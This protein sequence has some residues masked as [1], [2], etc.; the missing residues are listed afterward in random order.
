MQNPMV[1]SKTLESF[2]DIR[3]ECG[4]GRPKDWYSKP[5]S[6]GFP[7]NWKFGD[8]GWRQTPYVTIAI[9][10][11]NCIGFIVT[12]GVADWKFVSL[13]KN[14]VRMLWF[15]HSILSYFCHEIALA[16]SCLDQPFKT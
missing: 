9:I 12:M 15:I 7:R 11:I 6:M 4:A 1:M 10:I 3:K 8:E 13:D 5:G 2:L 16:C 14:S